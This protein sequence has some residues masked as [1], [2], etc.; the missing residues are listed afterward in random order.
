MLVRCKVKLIDRQ[1]RAGENA[2]EIR[3]GGA[4]VCI[5]PTEDLPRDDTGQ[6]DRRRSFE[7]LLGRGGLAHHDIDS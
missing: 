4:T 5:A 6:A 3:L 7:T 1:H 2:H